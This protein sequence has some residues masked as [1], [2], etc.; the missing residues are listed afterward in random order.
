MVKKRIVTSGNRMKYH[1]IQWV[2]YSLTIILVGLKI[3]VKILYDDSV[4]KLYVYEQQ[5]NRFSNLLRPLGFIFKESILS[6][7]ANELDI[8]SSKLPNQRLIYSTH[9]GY[10]LTRYSNQTFDTK[11]FYNQD[12]NTRF[13]FLDGSSR[14]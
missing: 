9:N 11:D 8:D 5:I 3:L 6:W 4:S 7:I 10:Y 2:M 12:L 13:S 14:Y 1:Y